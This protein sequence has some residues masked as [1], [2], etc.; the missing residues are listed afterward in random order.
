[1]AAMAPVAEK[2]PVAEKA[3]VAAVAEKDPVAAVAVVA[4]RAN[5]IN[6]FL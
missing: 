1:M 6:Q 2:D 4:G 3:A 5:Q